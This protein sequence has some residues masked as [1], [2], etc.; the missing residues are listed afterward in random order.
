MLQLKFSRFVQHMFGEKC[1]DE[2]LIQVE[3]QLITFVF[4]G[5]I[6]KFLKS[7][8]VFEKTK[9]LYLTSCTVN[10]ITV[11]KKESIKCLS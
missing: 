8:Q 10:C 11:F 4:S 2:V 6:G 9:Y 1:F 5:N 3:K 7:L